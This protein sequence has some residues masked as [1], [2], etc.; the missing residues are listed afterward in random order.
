MCAF[1]QLEKIVCL[2]IKRNCEKKI[3]QEETP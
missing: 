3:D 1:G 2:G